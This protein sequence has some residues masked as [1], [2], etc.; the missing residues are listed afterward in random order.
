[1]LN[2]RNNKLVLLSLLFV[3]AMLLSGCKEKVKSG[4]DEIKRQVITGVTLNVIKPSEVDEYYETA[5]TVKAKTTSSIAGRI[6]GTITSL[7]VKEGDMVTAGQVLL[8]IDDRELTE[9]VKSAEAGYREALKALEAAKQNRSMVDITFQR[10]KKLFDGKAISEQ[11][12]DQVET[13]KKMADI[14]FERVNE[15]VNRAKA[16][17][18]EVQVSQGFTAIKSPSA[19]IVTEK[20]TE[21]GSMAMPGMPLL[22]VED[23][24]AL[25]LEANVDEKISGKLKRGMSVN[26]VIDSIGQQIKGRIS[27]IVPV[28]DPMSRTF[29]V[30]IEIKGSGLRSGLYARIK[31]PVGKKEAILLPDTA[32]VE[33]GQLTGV[34]AVDEKG[35][36]SY[37][38][39]RTGRHY[40]RNV[41]VLSGLKSGDRVI[42][43]G[44]ARAVDGGIVKGTDLK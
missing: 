23:V 36:I 39:I 19:G 8:T 22:T 9:R 3:Y 42:T 21:L 5:G 32:I 18:A 14:E 1:M 24:S 25:R 34:Y 15:M 29:P 17:L 7:K 40:D 20:K 43:E 31:I 13:Q 37:R 16:G 4:T 27:E 33:R 12:I 26:V 6:M 10:Y 11:E 44:V 2:I 38:L 35:L 41:E 30:K 28:I